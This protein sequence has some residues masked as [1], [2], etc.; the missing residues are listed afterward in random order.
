MLNIQLHNEKKNEEKSRK[1]CIFFD[2]FDYDNFF[3]LVLKIAL[4]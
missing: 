2:E 4:R 3:F 1:K